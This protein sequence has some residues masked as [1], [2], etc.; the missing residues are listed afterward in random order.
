MVKS[1]R[2]FSPAPGQYEIKGEFDK[3]TQ[4][5]IANI[6]GCL[7]Y[8]AAIKSAIN[9]TAL[10]KQDMSMCSYLSIQSCSASKPLKKKK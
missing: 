7:M 2:G 6:Q 3:M 1:L 4:S 8:Q 10:K 5:K 9:K